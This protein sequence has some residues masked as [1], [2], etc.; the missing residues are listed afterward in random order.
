MTTSDD[1]LF[2]YLESARR[3][4]SIYDGPD[5]FLSGF[6]RLPQ[7]VGDLVATNWLVSE[8]ENG[9]L[10]QFF[11]NS[12]GVLSPEALAGLRRLDLTVA[13]E[14]MERAMALIGSPYP[15]VRSER[16]ER[17]EGLSETLLE[18][19]WDLCEALGPEFSNFDDAVERYI[20]IHF[21]TGAGA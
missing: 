15:R 4:V 10:P 17:L 2:L 20:K 18:L 7:A 8:V 9:D 1:P 14:I 11:E 19:S 5:V 13:A 6:T 12:T 21:S 16:K 3:S